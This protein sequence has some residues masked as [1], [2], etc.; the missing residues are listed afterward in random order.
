MTQF[1][2]KPGKDS[3]LAESRATVHWENPQVFN[4]NQELP[5]ST[6][7]P[8][9]NIEG[10][11]D[12]NK[13]CSSYL[14]LNGDWQFYWVPKPADRP[15]DFYKNNY[16]VSSWDSIA[17]PSNV[18]LKGYGQ[19]IYVNKQYPFPKNPPFIDHE[20]NPVSSYKREFV[21]PDG[22]EGKEV[23]IHFAGVSS[24]AFYWINGKELGYS[25][26][27]K[28]PIEFKLTPFL[29]PGVNVIAVEV[30]KWCD[31]SYLEGQDFW[32]LSGIER[33]VYLWSAPKVYVRDFFVKAGLDEFYHNGQLSVEVCLGGTAK[34]AGEGYALDLK[35]LNEEKK[36]VFESSA[37]EFKND[38]AWFTGEVESPLRWSAETPNLYQLVLI[39]KDNDGQMTEIVG[40]KVGFRQIEIS[41]GLLRINGVPVLIKGVNRHEHDDRTGHVI[42]EESIIRDIKLMKQSNINAV[43]LGH[44]PNIA[45]WYELCDKYGLYVVDEANIESHAMGVR[46][47]YDMPYNE[48]THPS[49]LPEW[50]AAHLERIEKMVET[51]KNHPSI[52]TW[53]L[54]NEAGNG[55]NFHEAYDWLKKRDDTRPVQYEQAGEDNN[56]DIVCPMY[57]SI[58]HLVDYAQKDLHRPLI[59]C[60]YAHAMGNS[61]GNLREYWN[62]IKKFDCLQGGF[63]WDWVDQGL[64]VTNDNGCEYW[65]YGGD[66]EPDGT[67]HDS[68]FCINGLV[69]PD[70]T[71]HP[72]LWEVKKVYQS[73]DFNDAGA[74]EGKVEIVN[75][76]N[77][78]ELSDFDFKWQLLK[79]GQVI[80]EGSL[81]NIDL[82][83]NQSIVVDLPLGKLDTGNDYAI[84]LF[85]LTRHE[86]QLIPKGHI[87]ASEQ[88]EINRSHPAT[89]LRHGWSKDL[90]I[91]ETGPI[92]EITSSKFKVAFDKSSGIFTDYKY[93]G[94]TVIK[95]GVMPHFWRA[96]TDNDFGNDMP[97][98]LKVWKMASM[99]RRLLDF[100]IET[101]EHYIEVYVSYVLDGVGNKF[102]ITYQINE[103]GEI[104]V[105]NELH[106]STDLLPEIPRIGNVFSINGEYDMLEWYGRG[107]FENYCD[108][109]SAAFVGRYQSEVSDLHTPYIRP[110][111]NGYRTDVRW[112]ELRNAKGAG[113]HIAGEGL[114]SICAHNYT[115]DDIDPGNEKG[116]RS[117]H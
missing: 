109:R 55:N 37:F 66:F 97:E 64:K 48:V 32:R 36:M 105:S 73:I 106:G 44:Y 103:S 53:S 75:S 31:G 30:Y 71:P 102:S 79:D 34:I 72:A 2:I 15:R 23:F 4:I 107:P 70:R 95:Q 33:E 14:S 56:T 111:E 113:I 81:D 74:I 50:K 16:D 104:H 94:N 18:E 83:P 27:S 1:S 88:I 19:P 117:F 6:F 99:G 101:K 63:I 21:L 98:R 114:L 115:T 10:L 13:E 57:P 108:R 59:M 62:A 67:P 24:A 68:N 7:L 89:I 42:S 91:V 20:N 25:Q 26:D 43:R 3:D 52:I 58:E 65:A 96:P 22:W 12:G 60:E 84:N 17:V 76:Y 46:F 77:F 38:K 80:L 78:I 112:L 28:T 90:Q 110:Q 69:L 87:L 116:Q 47:Q 54:G 100:N 41:D 93:N 45:R 11:I 85:A 61:V 35:L 51:N 40:C 49:N 82:P 92:L 39:L 8:Y 5:R 29:K 86:L 9:D